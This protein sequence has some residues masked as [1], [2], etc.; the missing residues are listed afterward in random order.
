MSVYCSECCI[1]KERIQQIGCLRFGADKEPTD[2][3]CE[4]NDLSKD[5]CSMH[6][7][8]YIYI[9][10][11]MMTYFSKGQKHHSQKYGFNVNSKFLNC[12]SEKSFTHICICIYGPYYLGPLCKSMMPKQAI[13]IVNEVF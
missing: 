10:L 1:V 5:L 6:I 3:S 4:G 7:Y 2:L 11:H 9:C 8:I 12:V 13:Q